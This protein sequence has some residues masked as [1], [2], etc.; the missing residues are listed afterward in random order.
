MDD[1]ELGSMESFKFKIPMLF[2]RGNKDFALP[3]SIDDNM[4]QYFTNISQYEVDGGHWAHWEQP[5]EVNK[6]IKEFFVD[7]I[8][9]TKIVHVKAQ[10]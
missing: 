5:E 9:T 7:K 6:Y 3:K 8:D 4:D 10:F 1:K 2:I